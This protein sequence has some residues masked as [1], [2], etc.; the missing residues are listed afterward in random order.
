MRRAAVVLATLFG[1]GY[2]PYVSGTL[3]T[4]FSLIACIFLPTESYLFVAGVLIGGVAIVPIAYSAEKY[5]GMQDDRRIV[6][7]ELIGYMVAV[8]LL[9][10]T[11]GF[12]L[13]A[14][15]L[16]RFF[17]IFKLSW[18]RKSQ[19]LPYGIGVVVDDVLAGLITNIIL[20]IVRVIGR[21]F[22]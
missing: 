3:G 2:V 15:I 22:I 19:S 17:D 16:F 13:A 4:V 12:F 10:K 1:I 14:F 5:F 9:P 21:I 11:V 6:I 20:Q 7:D 18:I 8:A